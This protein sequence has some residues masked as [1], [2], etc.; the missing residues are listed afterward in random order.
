MGA[1]DLAGRLVPYEQVVAVRVEGV[2]VDRA[3]GR[4]AGAEFAGEDL[5]AQALG[6]PYSSWSRARAQTAKTGPVRGALGRAE[7]GRAGGASWA[8]RWA[9]TAGGAKRGD[10]RDSGR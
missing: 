9:G 7:S 6:G 8:G 2:G 4:R 3:R 10:G 1:D 5:V